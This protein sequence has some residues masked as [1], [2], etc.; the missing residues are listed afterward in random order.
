MASE[1]VD[2]F[3]RLS[4]YLEADPD[5]ASLLAEAAQAAMEADALEG[6]IA[7]FTRLDKVEPLKGGNAN[8]AGVAYMRLGDLDQAH[9]WFDVALRDDPEDA[10][11]KFN[12]AWA[13]S[14][15]GDF[16]GATELL[17]VDVIEALPQ[18]AMLDLQIAHQ[19]G[20]Y[21]EAEEKVA[22]YLGLFPDYA[23]LQA[24]VSVLALDLDQPDIARS[25]AERAGAIPDAMT[26][27]ATLEL[28]E[29][30]LDEAENLF[31]KALTANA[32][33]PRAEIGMGLVMLARGN[34]LGAAESLDKG[35][36]QFENHLGTWIAAGWA[37]LLA[38]DQ[39]A[40][41]ARFQK[42][43][44]LDQTF[45]EAHGSLAVLDA[46]DGQSE[47]ASRGARTAMRLDQAGFSGALASILVAQSKDDPKAAEAI[48]KR[49][50]D[51]PILPNGRTL[52]ESLAIQNF[53]K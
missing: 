32:H 24:A 25:A 34:A 8:A 43:I 26:T 42:A 3:E 45:G 28:G 5:N 13:K 17:E 53:R 40:A 51:Q 16:V 10:S 23:P 11:L 4:G 6:A 38:G 33:N 7:L 49:A 21:E 31:V 47:Q 1:H 41:R 30:N 14:L 18:A 22:T 27:L 20:Q 46:L 35:A 29:Q 39:T 52:M 15:A 44:D 37:H 9:H 2:R 48:L 12:M 19:L 50:L 36:V